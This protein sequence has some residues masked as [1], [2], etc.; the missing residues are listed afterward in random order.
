M[1][2]LAITDIH[3]CRTTFEALL[4]TIG[5][6]QSDTLYLLGDYVDR[7]PDSKGVID[8]IWALQRA[9]YTIHCLKGNHEELVLR[10]AYGNFTYLEKWLLTDG[11]DTMDSFGVTQCADIPLEYLQWM[12]QLP[13]YL[14]VDRYILV[15]A[16]L[17]FS[18]ADPLSDTSEMCWIR[19]WYQHI[20]Y[21]WL[22]DRI[23][24]HG[25]TPVTT[26]TIEYQKH[27]LNHSQYLDLD[28]GCVY[29]DPRHWKA[30]G[31]G[32]LCAFDMTNRALVF[33]P[34]LPS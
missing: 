33:Q 12:E 34:F 32:Q 16:G 15:H 23:I 31:L 26:E 13:Y 9:G 14:E 6:S 11:K 24:L 19:N 29:G 27:N 21:D 4:D 17:D 7:G 10:A 30:T 28:A 8:Q 25:H 22:Q 5:F 18:I 20:R 2:Q 3:G 1:R